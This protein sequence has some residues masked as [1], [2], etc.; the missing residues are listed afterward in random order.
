MALIIGEFIKR[1]LL[2][3]SIDLLCERPSCIVMVVINMADSRTIVDIR[4]LVRLEVLVV[5]I[6]LEIKGLQR[7]RI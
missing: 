7:R 3:S 4:L 2:V 6:T 5:M 1:C